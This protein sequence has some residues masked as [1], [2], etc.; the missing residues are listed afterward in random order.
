MKPDHLPAILPDHRI[1]Q[2]TH[3]FLDDRHCPAAGAWGIRPHCQVP[4]TIAQQRLIEIQQA[5]CHNFAFLPRPGIFPPIVQNFDDAHVR[6]DMQGMML[7]FGVPV[8]PPVEYDCSFRVAFA[9][10]TSGGRSK[11][12][13]LQC[14]YQFKYESFSKSIDNDLRIEPRDVFL[15]H[16]SSPDRQKN[17]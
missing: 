17:L 9:A 5:G 4:R 13:C 3:E 16:A 7:A 14:D 8:L 1:F 10:R 6:A 15:V 12:L 2:A 11:L